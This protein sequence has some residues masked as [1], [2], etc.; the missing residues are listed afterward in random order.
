ALGGVLRGG[1]LRSGMGLAGRTRVISRYSWERV[2]AEAHTLY[3]RTA[4][5][6]IVRS[7]PRWT[8]DREA[9]SG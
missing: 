4:E 9:M 7:G 6:F 8:A 2:A 5:E 1:A 3:E